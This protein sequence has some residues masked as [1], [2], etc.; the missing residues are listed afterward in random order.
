MVE[1]LEVEI[2]TD[3]LDETRKF[4]ADLLGFE[5]IKSDEHSFSFKAGHSFFSFRSS[6]NKQPQYHFAFNIPSNKI[7]EA[8][9]WVAQRTQVIE[10]AD[11]KFIADFDS[12]NA[13][14]FYFY[15]NNK[16]IVEFIARFDLDNSSQQDFDISSVEAI[17][18]MGIVTDLPLQFS[19]ELLKQFDL[20]YFSKEER[21]ENF[22]VM[23]D[24]SGLMII[25]K[26]N[27]NWYP[28][29]LP[30][31]QCYTRIKYKAGGAIHEMTLHEN[32]V[33]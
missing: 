29:N 13:K 16:N 3:D 10:L 1:I 14:A 31:K 32:N 12:W 4:Y 21:R 8:V 25:V 15:D 2:L 22:V 26:T 30:A 28:T 5:L 23:G 7:Y 33:E 18:E 17:S 9:R 19:E 27:R 11:K 6:D 20:S 24:D